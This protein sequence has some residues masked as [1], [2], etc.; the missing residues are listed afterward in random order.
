MHPSKAPGDGSDRANAHGDQV[1]RAPGEAGSALA[2]RSASLS[3]PFPPHESCSEEPGEGRG[4]AAA[5][6]AEAAGS[7]VERG[8][9]SRAE[10]SVRVTAS[11]APAG[12]ASLAGVRPRLEPTT[13][14]ED[15]LSDASCG[16]Q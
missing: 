3:A 13:S 4:L 16:G 8:C 1:S 11:R 5:R 15:E 14:L 7:L 9:P 6:A 10:P 2:V 12:S